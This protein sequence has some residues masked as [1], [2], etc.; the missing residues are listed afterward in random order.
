MLVIVVFI[1]FDRSQAHAAGCIVRSLVRRN[2]HRRTK[3]TP[4]LAID[5]A[6]L[7]F[8]PEQGIFLHPFA[9]GENLFDA[10][11]IFGLL[12][13]ATALLLAS[14]SFLW[15]KGLFHRLMLRAI[16]RLCTTGF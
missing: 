12:L 14:N 1:E 6:R 16:L 10:K 2:R 9:I 8:C 13:D 11:L 7:Q 5:F 15:V 4:F 3:C